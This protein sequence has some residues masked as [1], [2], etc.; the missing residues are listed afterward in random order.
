L[1]TLAT[2]FSLNPAAMAAS[3]FGKSCSCEVLLLLLLSSSK[4]T[5]EEYVW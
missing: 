4:K 1:N 2:S 3:F 5:E